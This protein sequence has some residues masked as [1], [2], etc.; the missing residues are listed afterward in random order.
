MEGQAKMTSAATRREWERAYDDAMQWRDW[1][2]CEQLLAE[3]ERAPWYNGD[4]Y[5]S[6]SVGAWM[7][8]GLRR[9]LE[10]HRV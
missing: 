7:R 9:F 3:R 4:P 10:K 1:Q 2:T 8:D 6:G 5:P